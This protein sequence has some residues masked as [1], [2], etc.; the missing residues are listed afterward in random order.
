M[1]FQV[2][3]SGSRIEHQNRTRLIEGAINASLIWHFKLSSDLT[4]NSLT[5]ALNRV[6]F[7]SD[8]GVLTNFIDKYAVNL[9]QSS[10][11]IITLV[12]FEVTAA[13]NGIFSCDVFARKQIQLTWKSNVQ[14]DVIGKIFLCERFNFD[15]VKGS[16]AAL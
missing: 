10:E 2:V 4:F 1:P 11:I 16:I 3:L 5:L 6:P 15:Y 8:T 13:V 14:V 12:I 9:I 7:A